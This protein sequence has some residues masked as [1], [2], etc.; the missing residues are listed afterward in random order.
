MNFGC[1]G[2]FYFYSSAINRLFQDG[3]GRHGS[4]E[5]FMLQTS[6]PGFESRHWLVK[7]K[8]Y[9]VAGASLNRFLREVHKLY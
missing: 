1:R 9:D 7:Q 2:C 6:F 8:I 4:V 5:V 3:E